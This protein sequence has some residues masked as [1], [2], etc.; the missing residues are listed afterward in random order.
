M[1]AK[2]SEFIILI[3]KLIQIKIIKM[4]LVAPTQT[5]Y[6]RGAL[7]SYFFQ[8]NDFQ[9][10]A[11]FNILLFKAKIGRENKNNKA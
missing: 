10:H 11:Q 2:N 4:G 3:Q 7:L 1:H 8:F 6:I 9:K 5:C